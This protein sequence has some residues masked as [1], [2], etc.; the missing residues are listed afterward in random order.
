MNFSDPPSPEYTATPLPEADCTGR[1]RRRRMRPFGMLAAIAA[2]L[3]A[4]GLIAVLSEHSSAP[5]DEARLRIS[6]KTGPE[7]ECDVTP[8]AIVSG[9]RHV[10]VSAET[11]AVSVRIRDSSGALIFASSGKR[12]DQQTPRRSGQEM[13]R[14]IAGEYTVDCGTPVGH[15]RQP[16]IVTNP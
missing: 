9:V 3:V 16:L 1:S 15:I 14:F 10:D 4:A 12:D 8:E 2:A 13:A 11:D 5:T 6:V 7:P